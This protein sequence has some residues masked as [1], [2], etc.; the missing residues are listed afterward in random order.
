MV[1]ELGLLAF[2]FMAAPRLTIELW[3]VPYLL[4]ALFLSPMVTHAE[5]TD[6][7]VGP[8]SPFW[9]TRTTYSNRFIRFFIWNINLH[10]AHHLIPSIPGQNLPKL[11]PYIDPYCKFTSKSY[12][13][14]HFN[15]ALRLL[16]R[17]RSAHPETAIAE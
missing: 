16:R 4:C 12:A 1:S 10:T 9:T 11:Q 8:D 7:G 5:H 2:G 6:C 17:D 13:A 14:W 3:L 15:F